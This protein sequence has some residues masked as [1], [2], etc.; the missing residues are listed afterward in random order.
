MISVS[1]DPAIYEA[2][3]QTP[4]GRWIADCEFNLLWGL[5]KPEAG[6]S[7]LDIGC[8]TGHFSRRFAQQG[9]AVTGIDPDTKSID[10]AVQQPHDICYLQGNALALPYPDQAFDYTSAITSFCFIENPQL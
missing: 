8:G 7:L 6:E 1:T 10:F 2:W 3:Y 5:L 4:R 9:L